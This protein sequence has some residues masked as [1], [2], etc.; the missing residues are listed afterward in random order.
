MNTLKS[1]DAKKKLAGDF[2]FGGTVVAAALHIASLAGPI[3]GGIFAGLPIRLG[4]TIAILG[5]RKDA[6][7]VEDMARGALIGLAANFA[8]T[9][10]L[11]LTL[12]SYGVIYSF[13]SATVVCFATIGIL[14]LAKKAIKSRQHPAKKKSL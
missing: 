5:F 3:A 13:V 12:K 6:L 2:F 11:I 8:F 4:L 9:F 10:T 1:G 14:S 7:F